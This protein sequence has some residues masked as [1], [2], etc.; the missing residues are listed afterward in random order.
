MFGFL[1]S[2]LPKKGKNAIE[3]FHKTLT[4]E[5]AEFVFFMMVRHIRMLLAL[6][7]PS[8]DEID[9]IKRMAPWQKSKLI[10]QAQTFSQKNLLDFYNRLFSIDV[11]MKTGNLATN[12]VQ[13]I[14]FLLL[15][16]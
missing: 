10:K 3:Q 11:A 8:E 12:L 1:D 16:L 15:S 6:S 7:S 14:D 5:E 2:I 4:T 13:T 9:E